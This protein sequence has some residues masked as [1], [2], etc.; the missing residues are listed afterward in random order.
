MLKGRHIRAR[1][2]HQ[3]AAPAESPMDLEY[4][5]DPFSQTSFAGFA[6]VN[7]M[8]TITGLPP[9]ISS[10]KLAQLYNIFHPSDP[11]AYRLEPLISSAMSS[12]KPQPLPYTKKTIS[13]SVSGI[14]AKVGQSVSGLWS[15][16]TSG[17]ASS[18][19]NRTLGLTADDVARMESPMHPR[20]VVTGAAADEGGVITSEIP[21]LRR[22]DT[23]EKMRQLAENTV[24]ADLVGTAMSAPTLIEGE[25]ET[26]YAGFQNRETHKGETRTSEQ[27]WAKVEEQGRKLRREEAKVR[28]LN[29]NGRV[30][31]S[32]QE[33]VIV[34]KKFVGLT[35]NK[36]RSV[37]DFNP[38]K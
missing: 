32:I 5:Q 18:L 25:L 31:Y 36:N 29:Q 20:P 23:N 34:R 7:N 3:D 9:T 15:G 27:S 28:A 11:I 4:M 22:E 35:L 16:L 1:H 10:P 37:L 26:L 2:S 14:S 12:M 21:S 6:P 17:I 33:Y 8:S 19:L 30:D 13:S 24:A 38:I